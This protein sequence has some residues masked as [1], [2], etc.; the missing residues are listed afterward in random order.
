[1]DGFEANDLAI[2][3]TTLTGSTQTSTTTRFSV[4]RSM[5]LSNY[6]W[7]A[8]KGL[9]SAVSDLYVGFALYYA[10]GG[11]AGNYETIYSVFADNGTVAHFRVKV[12]VPDTIQVMRYDG[13]VLASS[14]AGAVAL[15]S[16]QFMEVYG[17]VAD[18]GGR[19]TVRMNG[20][21]IID[22]TG[23]TKNG[24]TS[25][26]IDMICFGDA[27]LNIGTR[28]TMLID[29]LYVCDNTGSAPHNTFLGDVRVHTTSPSAAGNSTQFTPS[30]GANYAAVDEI[31]YSATDYV[32]A[33][34]SGTKDTYQMAD[35][36]VTPTTIFGVQTNLIAKK[37]DAGAANIRPVI[38]SGGVDYA[39]ASRTLLSNDR[40]FS[41]VNA[42]N[43]NTSAS[44]TAGGINAVEVGMEIV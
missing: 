2:K 17:K 22:F 12:A 40:T 34:P 36:S 23:D 9:P 44:W 16:W 8:Y 35:L 10:S 43:P 19:V 38:R 24:G 4:G 28:T 37:T 33:V 5:N 18:S 3:W 11:W 26:N 41:E 7:G 1:M 15:N 30:T 13:T 31:P 25:T 20:I 27:N 6:F 14:A 39:G 42:Q 21:T 32:S 29:D